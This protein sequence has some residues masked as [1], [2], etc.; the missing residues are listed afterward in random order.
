MKIGL[1]PIEDGL[2][3]FVHHSTIQG[4]GFKSLAE[5]QAKVS[6]NPRLKL[7]LPIHKRSSDNKPAKSYFA[8]KLNPQVFGQVL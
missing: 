5:G 1:V 4:D 7:S 3:V 2:D 6:A 8:Q